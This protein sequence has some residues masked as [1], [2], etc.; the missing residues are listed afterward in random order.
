MKA[1]RRL[2]RAPKAHQYSQLC[3]GHTWPRGSSWANSS[4]GWGVPRQISGHQVS[5]S[6]PHIDEHQ[7]VTPYGICS[8]GHP[9]Q[10]VQHQGLAIPIFT[11]STVGVWVGKPWANTKSS[12][13]TWLSAGITTRIPMSSETSSPIPNVLTCSL[14]MHRLI[15]K[16]CEPFPGNTALKACAPSKGNTGTRA[17]PRTGL[18]QSSLT[19]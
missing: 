15:S 5:S 8:P 10:V 18:T 3:P 9:G 14:I 16:P 1:L 12:Q 19:P 2:F 13:A 4:H 17:K 6:R 11:H 7:I